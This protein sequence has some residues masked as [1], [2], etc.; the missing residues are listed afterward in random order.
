M[1]CKCLSNINYRKLF[2]LLML[3]SVGV[4][5]GI[6]INYFGLIFEQIHVD[7]NLHVHDN[8]NSTHMQ[9]V[10]NLPKIAD[11][12]LVVPNIVHFIWFGKEKKMSFINYVSILSAHKIQKPDKIMLHCN[13]LPVGDYWDRIW[14]EVPITIKHKEPP[15][16]IHGQKLLHMYHK[17][18]VAKIQILQEYG[19]IY[20]DYDVI[21]VNSFD[22]LRKYDAVLGKEKPPKFIAGIIVAKPGATFLKIW[23]ESYKNNYRPFDWDFNCARVT[24]QLYMKRP[25]LLHVEPRKFT[26]PDWQDRRLL[27]DEVIDWSELYCVHVMLHLNW[28]EYSPENV[29]KLNSTFGE[30]VRYIYYG[31]PKIIDE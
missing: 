26:T 12:G 20:I 8:G 3:L 14:K 11:D 5:F 13:H 24:Y 23:H 17:G 25:D 28:K 16:E 30:V 29:K 19:G 2:S 1:A 15:E 31:S 27:W 18:D 22:P 9:R 10:H 6:V 7:V 4:V 21:M